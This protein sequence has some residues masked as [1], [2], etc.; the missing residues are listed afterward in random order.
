M[1]AIRH[2]DA[3][4]DALDRNGGRTQEELRVLHSACQQISWN[5]HPEPQ[6]EEAGQIVLRQSHF[7]RQFGHIQLVAESCVENVSSAIDRLFALKRC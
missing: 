5:G 2:T 4:C 6:L 3:M 1:L 7:I